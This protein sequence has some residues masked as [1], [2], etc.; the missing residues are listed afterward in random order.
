MIQSF[1]IQL[2]V[3]LRALREVVAPALDQKDKQALEQLHLSVAT[4]EFMQKRL[5]YARRYHR[6]E[7]DHLI[8][9]ARQVIEITATAR[10]ATA[11]SL[12][13]AISLGNQE[14]N[15]PEA[16]V[17]DYLIVSRQLRDLI[18]GA[19][20]DAAGQPFEARLDTLIVN[21]TEYLLLRERVWCLP[22]GF[23]L[24]PQDLPDL[25][26]LLDRQ[27]STASKY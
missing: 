25:D 18:S 27:E 5:P 2:Q 24:S 7:L 19:V 20:A 16:E 26:L 10:S 17:E 3:T 21:A 23:E 8:G 15:R 12:A 9:L 6:T 1:Q 11:E 22:L 13:K 4:L 14:L